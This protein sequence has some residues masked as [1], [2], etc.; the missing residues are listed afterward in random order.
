MT[1]LPRP[2]PPPELMQ[3]MDL[4]F[5]PSP[6]LEEWA[7][8]TFIEHG[9]T[10]WNEDHDHLNRATLG[11]VWTTVSNSRGG[12]MVAG[13]CES[14]PPMA[15]GKWQRAR[16]EQQIADWFDGLPDFLITIDANYATICQ[17]AEFCALIEHELYHAAQ[18]RDIYGAPKFTRD[19]RPKFGIKGHDVEEFV[20]VVRR[21]GAGPAAGATQ[22]LVDAASRRPEVASV[23]IAQACGTCRML[24]AA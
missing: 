16:A 18:E 12:N 4:Q 2:L 17:D 11:F 3:S 8:A 21:Y 9:A 5:M 7:R 23:K 19:G 10:L 1:G 6:E 13:Q 15:M 22:A 24:R 14:M 20:G